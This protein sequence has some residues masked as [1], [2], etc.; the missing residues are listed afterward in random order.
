MS[1]L[2]EKIITERK[3]RVCGC[4]QDDCHRCVVKTG[5][6]C[7]WVEDNLCSACVNEEAD[8]KVIDTRAAHQPEQTESPKNENDMFFQRLAAMGPIDI[9]MRIYE[10]NGKFTIGII[11]GNGDK[12]MKPMNFTGTPEEF[13]NEFLEKLLPQVQEVNGIIHNIDAVKKEA[14]KEL[15]KNKSTVKKKPAPAK[16]KPKPEKKETVKEKKQPEPKKETKVPEPSLFDA[17][18]AEVTTA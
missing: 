11:P 9:T 10:H 2:A 5:S 1:Q 16:A 8:I 18:A 15:E 17:P 12:L 14:E 7:Y 13:D 6:P 4:T 3:C